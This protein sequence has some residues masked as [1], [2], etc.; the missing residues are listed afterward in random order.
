MP[1]TPAATHTRTAS[2]TLGADPPREF[3]SVA[4]LLTFTER[5]IM[6]VRVL[7]AGCWVLSAGGEWPGAEC[8]GAE[9]PEH[10]APGTRHE[11][12]APGTRHPAPGTRHER[13]APGT[14]HA[15]P[16]PG[17]RHEHPA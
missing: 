6:T 9:C 7:G 2:R 8:F 16:A 4:I 14:R 10:P 3:R 13:P 15:H 5:R 12:P 1:G 17:T 11:R